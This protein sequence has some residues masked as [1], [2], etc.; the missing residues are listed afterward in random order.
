MYKYL[1]NIIEKESKYIKTTYTF[2]VEA[3][4]AY[5]ARKIAA[6]EIFKAT[7]PPYWDEKDIMCYLETTH[8]VIQ[9]TVIELPSLP[10]LIDF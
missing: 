2:E 7:F 10:P 6:Y 4:S 3:A 8:N 1:I 5:E 9:F